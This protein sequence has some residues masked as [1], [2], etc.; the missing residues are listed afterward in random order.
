VDKEEIPFP[1]F[2]SRGRV[3]FQRIERVMKKRD[4]ALYLNW[5]AK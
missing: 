2:V 4:Q 1:S 3:G 5:A